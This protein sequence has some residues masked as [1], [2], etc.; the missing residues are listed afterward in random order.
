MLAKVNFK[1]NY[2][3]KL[4]LTFS[5]NSKSWRVGFGWSLM[6]Y[7]VV[8]RICTI[9]TPNHFLFATINP[10]LGK[11]QHLKLKPMICPAQLTL[12]IDDG[13]YHESRG[14]LVFGSNSLYSGGGSNFPTGGGTQEGIVPEI[15]FEP[16]ITDE[17]EPPDWESGLTRGAPGGI[18]TSSWLTVYSTLS[19]FRAAV[20][21][22]SA[23]NKCMFYQE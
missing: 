3:I 4:Q 16:V 8:I 2:V 14:C 22:F 15:D 19:G 1:S 10:V 17:T 23:K 12:C 7:W 20:I 11:R 21:F 9:N 6:S 13:Q 5:Q 18:Q